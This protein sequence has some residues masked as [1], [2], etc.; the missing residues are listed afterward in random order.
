MHGGVSFTPYREQF[1]KLIGGTINYLEITMPVKVFLP[2]KICPT[3][4]GHV[5][6]YDHGIF[7]EF[8]PVEEYEKTNQK[9]WA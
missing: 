6:F 3:D 7:Y 5:A 8:L 2:R 4:E 9:H 1:E